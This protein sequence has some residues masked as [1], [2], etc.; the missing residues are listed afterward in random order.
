MRLA[1]VGAAHILPRAAGP[2]GYSLPL[3]CRGKVVWRVQLVAARLDTVTAR[4]LC[5]AETHFALDFVRPEHL[6]LRMLM[7]ALVLWDSV[8]PTE[9]WV[10]AQLPAILKVSPRAGKSGGRSRERL[11]LGAAIHLLPCTAGSCRWARCVQ[12]QLQRPA[13]DCVARARRAP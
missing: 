3:G 8:A 4:R 11:H 9:D 7:R 10:Q 2:P 12:L 5:R 13:P 1:A 6:Q